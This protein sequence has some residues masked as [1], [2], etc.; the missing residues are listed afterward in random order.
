MNDTPKPP[1]PQAAPSETTATPQLARQHDHDGQLAA[2]LPTLNS[3]QDL[4]KLAEQLHALASDLKQAQDAGQAIPLEQQTSDTAHINPD[5]ANVTSSENEAEIPAFPEREGYLALARSRYEARRKRSAVFNGA[6]LFGEPAW[7][8]LLDL[9]IAH[10]EGK[11]V[12]VSSACIGSASPP[13]T[14][15]RWLGV[16]QEAGLIE[17]EHDPRDQRRVLVYLSDDGVTRMEDYF[18]DALAL[19]ARS[20]IAKRVS[21]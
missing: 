17:R 4:I 16:L 12:S 19:D 8:I 6:E 21:T 7:D 13:T 3:R 5:E 18:R 9:D 20:P 14:G 11:H 10:A 15:L 1:A 2:R